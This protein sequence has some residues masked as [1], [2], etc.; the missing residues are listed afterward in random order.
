MMYDEIFRQRV[1]W[2]LTAFISGIIIG[3][4][5]G[6]MFGF[7]YAN[8]EVNWEFIHRQNDHILRMGDRMRDVE[9]EIF[10]SRASKLE[11]R[12]KKEDDNGL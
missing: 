3:M 11:K 12:L 2:A 6:F 10:N 9:K 8:R 1:L 4:V 5:C 7:G